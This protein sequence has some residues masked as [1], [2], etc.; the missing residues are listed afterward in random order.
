MWMVVLTPRH[1]EQPSLSL[2][3]TCDYCPARIV[4]SLPELWFVIVKFTLIGGV[5]IG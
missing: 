2:T 5:V 3:S 1:S 4:Y